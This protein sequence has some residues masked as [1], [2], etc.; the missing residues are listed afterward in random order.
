MIE[1]YCDYSGISVSIPFK[2]EGLSELNRITK[3]LQYFGIV[4][5]PFKREGLSE[6]ILIQ[7][8]FL[9]LSFNSLQTGR[10]FR[11]MS[12]ALPSFNSLSFNSLQTGRTF[13]T[14]ENPLS[15]L[16]RIVSIPFKREGLSELKHNCL[17]A[18]K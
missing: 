6:R 7:I 2:R 15:L 11:T 3:L 12:S 4:S 1:N 8:Q 16:V 10:T 14:N 18:R 17:L 9:I 13:R 5:I